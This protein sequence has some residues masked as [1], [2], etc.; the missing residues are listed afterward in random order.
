MR[1]RQLLWV[2]AGVLVLL[3]M[4]GNICYAQFSGNIQGV[5]GDSTGA[6]VQ[7]ASVQLTNKGTGVTL[8]TASD[9]AGNY[10]FVSLAPGAYG[11]SVQMAGFARSVIDLSLTTD[12]TLDV[13]VTLQLASATASV[14]VTAQ[15]PVLDTA[16]SRNQMTLDN[17]TVDSLPLPG[18]SM[19]ALITTAPG[20]LGL[21]LVSGSTGSAADNYS[22]ETQ[23]NDSANG[24]S[25]NGNMFILDGLDIGS[26]VRPD[27]LNLSPNPDSVQEVSIEVNTFNVDYGRA[28]SMQMVMTSKSGADQFH[29]NFSDYYTTQQFWAATEFVHHY[30]PFHGNNMSGTFGGP[31]IPHHQLF[32]FFSIEPLRSTV[33]TA[34]SSVTY[35][36]PAFTSWAEANYPNTVETQLLEKY[37]PTGATFTSVSKTAAQVFPTTCGTTA[38]DNLPCS[39]PMIDSGTFNGVSFRNGNQYSARVDKYFS[40]DRLYAN[41]YYTD[42]DT[43][44]ASPRPAF[45]STSHYF[46]YAL[47]ANETHTFSP[48]LLN[49]AVFGW[50]RIEGLTPNTGDYE[51]PVTTITGSS[52]GFGDAGEED[53]HQNSLH[54]RD[55]VSY[56]HGAHVFKF[57]YDGWEGN[58]VTFFQSLYAVP[59]IAFNNLLTFAQNSPH[60]ET[61]LSY[62][63]LTGAPEAGDVGYKSWTAGAFYED[64]W[65]LSRKLTVNYGVRYDD[66]GNP[67][68]EP[69]TVLSNFFLGAGTTVSQQVADGGLIQESHVFNHALADN[70]SPRF[71]VAWDPTGTGKW[72]VRGGAGIY[73]DWPTLGVAV[74][75]LFSNPPNY[76]VPTFLSGTTTPP[77]FALGTSNTYPFGYTY[78][79]FNGTTLNS[80]GG[81]TGS[82]ITIGGI[83]PNLK[84]P[85]T[86]TAALT[87]EH[88]IGKDLSASVGYVGSHSDH[89]LTD[90]GAQT[91]VSWGQDINTFPGDLIINDNVLTR[92]NHSFGVIN[93]LQSSDNANYN[94]FTASLKARVGSNAFLQASYTRSRSDDD[95]QTYPVAFGNMQYYGRSNWDAPNRFSLVFN[96]EFPGLNH[97][98]GAIGH[99]TGGWSLNGVS[100][101]QTGYPFTVDT[102][103]AFQPV[104]TGGVVTGL[105]AGSG[106]YNGDGHDFDMPNVTSYTIATTRQ[107][108]LTGVFTAAN[109]P[110]PALGTEGNEIWNGFRGPNFADTD[111]SLMKETA[112]GERVKLQ[113][114]LDAFNAFNRANL[115]GIDSN[116]ADSTFGKAI[117]QYNP[118]F[119][120]LG[121]NI[122]F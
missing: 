17:Q 121:A 60:S 18:R 116:L 1:T 118:R 53:Y 95:T 54:W 21:G 50:L 14:Q 29:G 56:I 74:Q 71:G 85:S 72:V 33:T 34:T 27:A 105:A 77:I 68:H 22:T 98:E 61:E 64:T 43:S 69:G 45:T 52:V 88:Q 63:P 7:K 76:V 75:R 80:Q 6:K 117:S 108:Y 57:G 103:A 13:P 90:S 99:I 59:D 5:V 31:I 42:L 58:D 66:F 12:Q 107:A 46:T 20:A 92:L 44:A 109:F 115:T 122:K 81:L 102:T 4:S 26:D 78:P 87:L 86:Y 25:S 89:L 11:L 32:F 49:Q 113:I 36:D 100:I 16:D 106:D 55:V 38:T 96:Y 24:R 93:Y 48:D 40:K 62:N 35:E 82:Q 65:K 97:G 111:L 112:I 39:T 41:F 94:G 8:T 23:V 15:A 91:T 110:I 28:S 120:Q 10:R 2:A 83:N 73:H 37:A 67:T 79:T 119:L 70:F 51:V 3:A 47:Q 84:T 104:V 19:I 114:R 9:D 101:F 30:I